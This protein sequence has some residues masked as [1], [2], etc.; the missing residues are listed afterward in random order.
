MC[1][2]L[3]HEIIQ[4]PMDFNFYDLYKDYS[5][6][7]L[8]KIVNRPD[9]YQPAAID[10]ATRILQERHVSE[11]DI[12]EANNITLV[13]QLNKESI[14]A[15]KEKA[16]DFLEPVL[17][18]STE[19]QPQKWLNI[20]LLVVAIQYVWTFFINGRDII[21][22]IAAV[23]DCEK[24][25]D[26]LLHETVTYWSCFSSRFNVM[27]FFE[28]F[29]LIY[30]PVTLYLLYKKY[31][32]GWIIFFIDSVFVFVNTLGLVFLFFKYQHIYHVNPTSYLFQLLIRGALVFFLWG[33]NIAMHFG[34]T[35]QIKRKLALTT[36]VITL[37]LVVGVRIIRYL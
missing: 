23:M 18:P 13:D 3:I 9:D 22:F 1:I 29:S 15:Y 7:D 34:V 2:I 20:L 6:A 11:A 36:V 12:Q 19:V 8:L 16:K 26:S 21:N 24:Y 10:A 33:D 27:L 17:Q 32:W 35:R 4:G 25:G 31:R 28:L 5:T 30:M 37:L 14:I